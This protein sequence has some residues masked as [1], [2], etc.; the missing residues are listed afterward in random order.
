[1]RDVS[2]MKSGKRIAFVSALLLCTVFLT[3]VWAG[4]QGDAW[5]LEV[6]GNATAVNNR[7]EQAVKGGMPLTEGTRITA[8]TAS[9]VRILYRDRGIF[10]IRN[11]ESFTISMKADQS[12]SL[13]KSFGNL[14]EMISGKLRNQVR[15][16]SETLAPQGGGFGEKT[17]VRLLPVYHAS[18]GPVFPM[19]GD[20]IRRN[21]LVF[22]WAGLD[23]PE[24]Y[25]IVLRRSDEKMDNQAIVQRIGNFTP[26][27]LDVKEYTDPKGSGRKMKVCRYE[28]SNARNIL[29]YD[30][31]FKWGVSRTR[32]DE[33]DSYIWF[34]VLP[35][36]EEEPVMKKCDEIREQLGLGENPV[37]VTYSLLCGALYESKDLYTDAWESYQS[38][39]DAVEP[40]GDRTPYE[41]ILQ[42]LSKKLK[43]NR[44][45]RPGR[46]GIE[47]VQPSL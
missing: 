46:S 12:S 24:K 18:S 3:S 30:F 21:R 23:Q 4:S 28:Y 39:I 33:P 10:T 47:R 5:V 41:K 13:G 20:L 17:N 11:G 36:R 35:Y 19:E 32:D 27:N 29:E 42:D 43:Q 44:T 37:S 38:A 31:Y 9:T 8:G 14:M 22:E 16:N 2:A 7:E 6:K 25:T 1:M 40:G 45:V 34:H 15:G 26:E